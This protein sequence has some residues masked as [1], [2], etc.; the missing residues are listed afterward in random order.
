MPNHTSAS[1]AVANRAYAILDVKGLIDNGEFVTVKGI[2]STPKTDRMGD[3]VDPMGA[4]FSTPMPLMLYHDSAL[5][6][7]QMIAARKSKAGIEFEARIPRI[8]EAGVVQDRVNE[9]IHSLQY[10]LIG[11]VSIGFNPLDYER[12]DSGYTFKEWDWLEL[13][14]VT[15]P[16]NADAVITGVKSF[17]LAL[18]AASGNAR[19]GHRPGV[20]G[21]SAASRGNS[22]LRPKGKAMQTIEQ[23]REERVNKAARMRELTEVDNLSTAESEEFELLDGEIKSLDKEIRKMRLDE[24]NISKAVDVSGESRASSS[25]SRSGHIFMKSEDQEEKF[26]GQNFVRQVIA[27]AL[28]SKMQGVRPSEVAEARWGKSSPTLVRVIKANE[29]AGGGE[30]SGKWGAELVQADTRYTGDFIAFLYGMTV[31]DRLGLREIPAN[32]VVKGQT[33]ANTGYWVGENKAI[34]N[35][36]PTFSSVT[37]SPLKVAAMAVVSNELL[38]DSTPAAEQLVRDSLV[39]SSSQR[40]DTTFISTAAAA[41]NVSP[42]GILNGAALLSSAGV[43]QAAVL[44]DVKTLYRPFIAAKE[45]SGLVFVMN[46]STAKAIGLIINALGLPAFPNLGASGGTLL[47]DPVVTGDNVPS[48]FIVLMKPSEIYRIG[49]LGVTVAVSQEATIEQSSAPI[50]NTATPT[51]MTQAYTSMFQEESTAIK[52]VRPINFALRRATG[53]AYIANA[54]YDSVNSGG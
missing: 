9:A 10:N 45:S 30:Q 1:K 34:P 54:D 50:G 29:I 17:D 4:K 39:E 23:V 22:T 44:A 28:A 52:V 20:S 14:L 3:V 43:D 18:R 16:A 6:V 53:V 15:I 7:G 25:A 21:N 35:S 24:I 41:A 27:K 11:A 31:Y 42:A 40:I 51:A 12:T 36:K 46:P 38:R 47:G 49:D 48:N 5:P 33:G 13:S 26:K 32:V 37:L 19:A 8:K 2:A